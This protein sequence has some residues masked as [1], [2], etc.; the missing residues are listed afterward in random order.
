[1]TPI[2]AGHWRSWIHRPHPT[3]MGLV[4]Q[5]STSWGVAGGMLASLVVCGHVLAGSISSSIGFVTATLFFVGG[6]IVGFLHGALLAYLGRPQ[7]VSRGKAVA[8][9]ALGAAYSVP[10]LAMGWIVAMAL[11][12]SALSFAAGRHLAFGASLLAWV[13]GALILGWAVVE[14]RQTLHNL[15]ARWP[16]ARA[17]LVTMLAALL[18]LVPL[19]TIARPEIWIL[20]VRPTPTAALFMA[21]AATLWIVGPVVVVG[22]AVLRSWRRRA[23]HHAGAQ[24]TFHG[25]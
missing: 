12:L 23:R 17:I 13:A 1:M 11:V 6:A 9:I 18:A 21:L 7:D 2:P 5:T 14:T 22:D 4:A 20:D 19:F 8:R 3:R 10:A 15:M 25:H 16:D 24:E